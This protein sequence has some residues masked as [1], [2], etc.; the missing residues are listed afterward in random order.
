MLL[1]QTNAVLPKLSKFVTL[2]RL[3]AL[4]RRRLAA[5]KRRRLAKML[6]AKM[7]LAKKLLTQRSNI[8]CIAMVK[9]S[10]DKR[11]DS[12]FCLSF[13]RLGEKTY[14]MICFSRKK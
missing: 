5:L 2:Q 10:L 8:I 3:A 7:L 14:K 12:F 4:K 9:E 6:L 1:L 11:Q 13:T